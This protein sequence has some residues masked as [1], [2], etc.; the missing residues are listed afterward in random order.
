M[1]L[2]GK[3]DKQ[4]QSV[5][6]G[7]IAEENSNVKMDS[8]FLSDSNLSCDNLLSNENIEC[9]N[10]VKIDE[11]YKG[12]TKTALDSGLDIGESSDCLSE[13]DVDQK[14]NEH[15]NGWKFYFQQN[16]DGDTYVPV[17]LIYKRFLWVV[18]DLNLFR[19]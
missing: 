16:D 2:L 13:L 17:D 10:I 11:T 19:K 12:E 8:G 1:E 15:E 5:K 7:K 3:R 18:F 6:N 14:E 9:D 4:P